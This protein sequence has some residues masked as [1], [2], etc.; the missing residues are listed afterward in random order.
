MLTTTKAVFHSILVIVVL[1][2]PLRA[3][4][5]E[6]DQYR[7]IIDNFYKYPA[8]ERE[9]AITELERTKASSIE[10][11][12][13]LGMLYFIQ[14]IELMKTIARAQEKKPKAEEVLKDKTVQ[15]YFRKAKAKYDGVE[16]KS[17]GYK[18]IY[19]KYGELYRYSFDQD[20][21]RRVTN[22]V[23]H[24]TE[25]DRLRQCKNM[26]ENA[27]EQ[28]VRYGYARLSKVIYEEAV[29]TWRPYPIYMLE[30]LGDIEQVQQNKT[31]ALYWWKRCVAEAESSE[32]KQRCAAKKGGQQP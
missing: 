10:K 8:Q 3:P 32:R 29:K 11:D 24:A 7:Q 5:D 9:T 31:K 13:L 16:S 30:A 28:F 17:P 2:L 6:F 1:V 23:G 20:G 25:N 21:L 27:A 15:E 4:A 19:C 14:G 18:Y 22:H 12:Y 26:L